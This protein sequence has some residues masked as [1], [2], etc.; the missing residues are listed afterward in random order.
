MSI[1]PLSKKAALVGV[2]E[3]DYVR[4]ADATPVQLMIQA[5][6]SAIE[7]AGLDRSDIDGIIPPPGYTS[8]EEI[9]SN[10]GIEDLHYAVTVHLGGAQ[11]RSLPCRA[12]RPRSIVG[13]QR[14]CW[15]SSGGMVFPRF[16]RARE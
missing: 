7:D 12:Q 15:W 10:L 9:A 1:H 6:I 8:A 11:A 16:A 3:T 14:M 13:S 5:A 2:G 4:G